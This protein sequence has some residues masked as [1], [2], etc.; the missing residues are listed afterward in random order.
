MKQTLVV[1][2]GLPATGKTT[3]ARAVADILG[4]PLFSKDDYKEIIFDDLGPKV[5]EEDDL[6]PFRQQEWSRKWSL[7]V[8]EASRRILLRDVESCLRAGVSC[9]TDNFFRQEIFSKVFTD[10]CFQYGFGCVQVLCR[11]DGEEVFRRFRERVESGSRHPGHDDGKLVVSARD[12]LL[13]GRLEP[14]IL[15]GRLIEVDTT[16]FSQVDFEAIATEIRKT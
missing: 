10:L 15:P 2:N 3:L 8:G 16:D 9:M 13:R 1:V 14:L 12:F 6:S 4:L 7:L 5:G 11:A